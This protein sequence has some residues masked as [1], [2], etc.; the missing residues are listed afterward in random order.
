[1][2]KRCGYTSCDAINSPTIATERFLELK[3]DLV[4][5]DLKMEPFSG[6]DVLKKIHEMTEPRDRPP[7]VMITGD[8]DVESKHLALAAGASAFL[9]KPVD[10]I[11]VVLRIENLLT[12]RDLY[13]RCQLYS[14]GLER[15]LDRRTAELE[16][17]DLAKTLS[18]LREKQQQIIEQE[19]MRALSTM[20]AG[21][22]HDLN[23]GLFVILSYGEELLVDS[24]SFPKESAARVGL[25]K[26]VLAGR[27]S[28]ELVKRLGSFHRPAD[29]LEQREPVDL[30]QLVEEA[31]SLTAPRWQPREDSDGGTIRIEKNLGEIAPVAGMPGELREVLMN[32]IFNSVDAMPNGGRLT[33]RTRGNRRGVR[34]DV[35][36]T[37][38]GMTPETLHKCFEP[39]FTT[40]GTSGSGLGLAMSYGIIRRH[41]GTITARSRLNKGTSVTIFLPAHDK[42]HSKKA[43]RPKLRA[44]NE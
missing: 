43:K 2:L 38:A 22:A 28:A 3:P 13:L 16:T 42:A 20:A 33:L 23:N 32:L 9:A 14:E 36:D 5:L 40:K 12:T 27:D 1:M 4:L 18:V 7:V 19:R 37:G 24:K 44:V 8:T 39:F 41:G 35:S 29:I 15:L 10:V 30:N 31:L 21:I 26:M 34:L 25:E 11:E 17:A 6:I